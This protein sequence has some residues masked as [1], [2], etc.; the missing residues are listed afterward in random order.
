ME[1]AAI[2]T[3]LDLMITPDTATC[4]P[5]RALG[6]RVWAA[7]CTVDEARWLAGR[8]DRRYPTHGDCFV[9]PRSATGTKCSGG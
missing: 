7:L 9:K 8:E 3:H 5:G 1:T 2:M 6:L 4:I